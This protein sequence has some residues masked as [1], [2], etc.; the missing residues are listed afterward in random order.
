MKD[1]VLKLLS[2]AG[3]SV[4]VS[5]RGYR[6]RISLP[7]CSVKLL[8]PQNIV[9]MLHTGTRDLGFAGADWV[10]NLGADVVE[11]LDTKLD[12]VRLVVAAPSEEMLMRPK[13]RVASEYEKITKD[14]ITEKKLDAVFIRTFGATESFPP[15]DADVIVDNTATGETLRANNLQIVDTIMLSS[16]RLYASKAAIENPEK[17]KQ[18]DEIVLVIQSVLSGRERVMVV[19]NV[20]KDKLNAVLDSVPCMRAPSVAELSRDAGYAISVCVKKDQVAA[21]LP[22]LKSK[23]ATDIIVTDVRQIIA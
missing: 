13:L 19:F 17:K 18:I 16:T 2:E 7:N 14:Y 6:P 8:K 9:E 22:A 21:L 11:L 12:P 15:E 10:R 23:G 3:I 5:D 4:A 1:N 20:E